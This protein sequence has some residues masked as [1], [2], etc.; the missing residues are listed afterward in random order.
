MEKSH[1]KKLE[2]ESIFIIREALVKAKNPVLL[3]SIGKDSN[4]LLHLCRKAFFPDKIPLPLLHIDTTWKFPEM[5]TFRDQIAKK[6]NLDVKVYTNKFGV[7]QKINPFTHGSE[8]YTDIM[9][10]QALKKALDE[11]SYDF[12]LAGARRDEEPSRSKERIFSIRNENHNWDPKSQRAEFWNL[13]NTDLTLNQSMR[14]FPISNWTERDIWEYIQVENIKIPKLYFSSK[15]KFVKRNGTI[16]SCED[17]RFELMNNEK[18]FEDYIRF[19]TLGCYPLTG[20]IKSEARTI[21]DILD[22]LNENETGERAGRL[23]DKDTIGSME[24][25]KKEGYF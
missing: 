22:E 7:E 24:K 17:Q 18:V 16:I 19:R 5:I 25:K 1:L 3:Y 15:R 2:E 8:Y 9:K 20:G 4:V 23:I 13:Y 11:N 10:T 12:I 14:V 6:F 21:D